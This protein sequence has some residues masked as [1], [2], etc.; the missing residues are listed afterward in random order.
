MQFRIIGTAF[1]MICH[2]FRGSNGMYTLPVS[3]RVN[4][5]LQLEIS[6]I[7]FFII[8]SISSNSL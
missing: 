7:T 1:F 4:G 2:L 5:F 3:M 6:S 8:E